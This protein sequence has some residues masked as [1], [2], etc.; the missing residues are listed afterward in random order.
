MDF[1]HNIGIDPQLAIVQ[2]VGFLIL[3]WL[4]NKFAYKPI[5][6]ILD[7]RQNNI[8]S[9]YDQLDR[10][11]E[12]MEETKRLYESRLA[13]IEAEAREQIQAALKE[14]QELRNGIVSDAQ[15]Q[16]QTIIEKSRAD[17]DRERQRAFLSMRQEIVDL[18]IEAASKVVEESLNEARHQAL[19][20]DFIN[21]VGYPPASQSSQA[22]GPSRN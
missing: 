11:R 13:G 10:D 9:V 1:L 2:V 7:E 6:G 20:N 21:V 12:A 16:A 3:L 4:L 14:A 5:F 15:K 17:A 22:S 18:A 19:V 8:Q